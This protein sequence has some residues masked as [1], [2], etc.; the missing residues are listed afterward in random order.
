MDDIFKSCHITQEIDQQ[1][2]NA[3]PQFVLYKKLDKHK[4]D[5]YCTAC[6]QRYVNDDNSRYYVSNSQIKHLS[7]GTCSQCGAN[8]TYRAWDKGRKSYRHYA[9][10]A[11]FY[12]IDGVIAVICLR[13]IQFFRSWGD[14]IDPDFDLIIKS[15]YTFEQGSAV[16]YKIVYVPSMGGYHS[17]WGAKVSKP[18]EPVFGSAFGYAVD[19]SYTV[20]NADV[21]ADSHLRYVYND[22]RFDDC[23]LTYLANCSVHPNFEYLAKGGFASLAKDICY[24]KTGIRINWR[25]DDLKKMLRLNREEIKYL[26]N[27]EGEIIRKY[28]SFCKLVKGE[29]YNTDTM[30]KTFE[31][32]GDCQ[33]ILSDIAQLA[34][35]TVGTVI[36]YVNKQ[37]GALYR[38]LYDYKDY[39]EQCVE[40]RYNLDDPSI[41]MP[42]NLVVAHDRCTGIMR[43][44]I[45][46][47]AKA[48]LEKS[49]KARVK[50]E[51][52]DEELGL[53]IVLPKSA[54]EIINEG[55][56]LEHCVGGYAERHV[57]GKL[58][59]AFLRKI[60]EMDK[61][62]YTV[63]ISN[64]YK[65]VQ[66]R[67]Y[68]NNY[69]MRG[70]VKK[71]QEIITFEKRY[72][73]Y[74][75]EAFALKNAKKV[76]KTA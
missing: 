59:I 52:I 76:R 18:S 75:D 58:T 63:E 49:D 73:Q 6:H 69:E 57:I 67:G 36:D 25:S 37:G 35:I 41:I 8:I 12:K 71:P 11:V 19:N 15:K 33:K 44:K 46:K 39:L 47:K 22:A 3:L 68:K 70:G 60:N 54:N 48:Q 28:I 34:R 27:K 61:P 65:I 55:K 5:C 16:Q 1:I 23:Y 56:K 32:Y 43:I 17:K 14:E 45:D 38:R 29:R 40:L 21:M 42:H 72:Q 30:I 7:D 20:I 50:M 31:R 10:F 53:A 9:N 66:C 24:K 26:A 64:D 51:Y 4:T 13:A 74:L 2:Y 62:Y